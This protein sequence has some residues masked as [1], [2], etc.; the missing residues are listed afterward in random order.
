MGVKRVAIVSI[1]VQDQERARA[2]YCDKLGFQVIRE[3]P[4]GPGRR[5]VQIGPPGPEASLT[6]FTLVTWFERMPPGSVQGLV[7]QAPELDAVHARL[8]EAGVDISPIKSAVWGRYATFE[9]PDGNGLVLQQ[10]PQ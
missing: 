10:D 4:M 1:P 6:T 2:F 5:W 9:D 7:L 8:R 3:Q